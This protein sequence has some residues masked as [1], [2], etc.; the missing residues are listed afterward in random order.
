V[1]N[2]INCFCIKTLGSVI[3]ALYNDT[4]KNNACS[5]LDHA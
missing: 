3:N 1:P 5:I 2:N 4:C